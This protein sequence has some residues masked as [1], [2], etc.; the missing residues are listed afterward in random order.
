MSLTKGQKVFVSTSQYSGQ[1]IIQYI[2]HKEMFGIQVLLDVPDKDGH[3]VLRVATYEVKPLDDKE[4]ILKPGE[5]MMATATDKNSSLVDGDTY[6]IEKSTY[7]KNNNQIH[8]YDP[9]TN[10]LLGGCSST[11]FKDIRPVDKQITTTRPKSKTIA[12]LSYKFPRP[13][14]MKEPKPIKNESS[15]LSLDLGF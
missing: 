5:R 6:L 13:E 8:Y 10:K 9:H 3:S 14:K 12:V 2:D 7:S 11:Y 1:G 4:P 15:Q